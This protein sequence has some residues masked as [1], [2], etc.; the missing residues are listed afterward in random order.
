MDQ[1]D[2]S[3]AMLTMVQPS[4]SQ[5]SKIVMSETLLEVLGEDHLRPIVNDKDEED[6]LYR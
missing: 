3:R 6:E 5:E 1:F 2:S 4:S